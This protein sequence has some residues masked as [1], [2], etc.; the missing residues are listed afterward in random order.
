MLSVCP[1]LA[2]RCLL[3]RAQSGKMKDI[4]AKRWIDPQSHALVQETTYE[5]VTYTRIFERT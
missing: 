5:G 2:H 3:L 1:I 4:V